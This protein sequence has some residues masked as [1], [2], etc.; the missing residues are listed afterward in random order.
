MDGPAHYQE[1]EARSDQA[2]GMDLSCATPAHLYA[3]THAVL[4]LTAAV[5]HLGEVVLSEVVAVDQNVNDASRRWEATFHPP[6]RDPGD[7]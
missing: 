5:V 3:L 7:E 6:R 2:Y 4:S 1:A